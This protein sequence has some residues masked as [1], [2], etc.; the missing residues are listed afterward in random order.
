MS[1]ETDRATPRP[2]N[3]GGVMT[4]VEVWPKGWNVPMHI[5]DCDPRGRSPDSE[6]ERV[7][8]A[9]LIV[10]AVNSHDALVEALEGM[11]KLN[12][13]L[14]EKTDGGFYS[15]GNNGYI[16][17]ARAALALAR[18]AAVEAGQEGGSGRYAIIL[19]A[20]SDDGFDWGTDREHLLLTEAE[21]EAAAIHVDEEGE[22]RS[23]LDL[24]RQVA[25]DVLAGQHT[26]EADWVWVEDITEGV[27][28][29]WP[30]AGS[31]SAWE[32]DVWLGLA[33]YL[34]YRQWATMICRASGYMIPSPAELA[35]TIA[36]CGA[37]I[38]ADA[39]DVCESRHGT[40]DELA[41]AL[42]AALALA[43]EVKP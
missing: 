30:S 22:P 35:S 9:A 26:G 13:L 36:A 20:E 19:P 4:S 1:N 24:L 33:D 14:L 39:A 12:S 40:D 42:R 21:V 2:W 38:V 11:V 17:Q 37:E 8:N 27:T 41:R 16:Q 25:Q 15:A 29:E 32:D 5:A 23:D 10:R 34:S 3:T 18:E 28:D 43:G 31:A 7:A 6:Q